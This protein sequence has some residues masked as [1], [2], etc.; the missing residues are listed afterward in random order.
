MRL[1][2]DEGEQ[3]ETHADGSVTVA[4]DPN[5][6]RN[7]YAEAFI[8]DLHEAYERGEVWVVDVPAMNAELAVRMAER[9]E[10]AELR[11]RS[12]QTA[13]EIGEAVAKALE[14]MRETLKRGIREEDE[15]RKF[16]QARVEMSYAKAIA[17]RDVVEEARAMV[18]R[19][20]AMAPVPKE[21]KCTK[22]ELALKRF[23]SLTKEK[24]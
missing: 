23:D 19:L 15:E 17:L 8:I 21:M 24:P 14:S 12:F 2:S 9:K 1:V 20:D 5:C 11:T 4:A 16:R 3:Y 22:I 6:E 13:E 18:D 10:L 7:A